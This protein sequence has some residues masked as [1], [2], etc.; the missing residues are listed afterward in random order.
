MQLTYL[1][2]LKQGL[3]GLILGESHDI[4]NGV[5]EGSDVIAFGLLLA[6]GSIEGRVRLPE[7]G[8]TVASAAGVLKYTH[9]YPR[10]EDGLIG[11]PKNRDGDLVRKGKIWLPAETG[12]ATTDSLYWQLVE[13]AGSRYVGFLYPDDSGTP[14]NAVDV[15]SIVKP[16]KSEVNAHAI[17]EL[18]IW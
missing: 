17:H 9:I 1:K 18:F 2:Y 12:L 15:S 10:R 5:P 8:D 7:V 4:I 6:K 11:V 13:E 3:S 16:F 14:G